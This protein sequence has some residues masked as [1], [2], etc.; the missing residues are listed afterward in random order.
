M[1]LKVRT[2]VHKLS[3]ITFQKL[4]LC[5]YTC[6]TD[7]TPATVTQNTDA[8]DGLVICPDCDSLP[9]RLAIMVSNSVFLTMSFK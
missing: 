1:I 4:F 2:Y 3:L 7:V 9:K 5:L 8:T 6:A